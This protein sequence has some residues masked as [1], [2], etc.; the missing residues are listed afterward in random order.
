MVL[1]KWRKRLNKWKTLYIIVIYI[2]VRYFLNLE[3]R[4]VWT[5]ASNEYEESTQNKIFCF[6]LKLENFRSKRR[7]ILQESWP[8]ECNSVAFLTD[9]YIIGGFPILH[10]L[11][12]S[13]P[14]RLKK[15]VSRELYKALAAIEYA[16]K[17]LK[18]FDWF[19][20]AYEDTFVNIS[21]VR[22][23]LS[24]FKPIDLH[25]FGYAWPGLIK[26][27]HK[28]GY[29]IS[30]SSLRW[31]KEFALSNFSSTLLNNQTAASEYIRYRLQEKGVFSG[32]DPAIH[33]SFIPQNSIQ[34]KKPKLILAWNT[35]VR[36]DVAKLAKRQSENCPFQCILSSDKS[37]VD[38]ADAVTVYMHPWDL[39]E[40][41]RV[42]FPWQRYVFI[43]TE[44]YVNG[45]FELPQIGETLF[46]WSM[47]YRHDSDIRLDYYG[48]LLRHTQSPSAWQFVRH[49]ALHKRKMIAWVVSRCEAHS[50]RKQSLSFAKSLAQQ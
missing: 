32:I 4:A 49:T 25:Y 9:S 2:C 31:L 42:R 41:P 47:T 36:R 44:T 5:F 30:R 12:V 28:S 35:L 3:T 7:S 43:N 15:K 23:Y 18:E 34:S 1:N 6:V 38:Q 29:I 33:N 14:T 8:A 45:Q 21:N 26:T 27:G 17:H 19:L 10:P 22:H 16:Y 37:I 50:K 39:T 46:N 40:M 48:Q 13:I 24:R 20:L 11:L